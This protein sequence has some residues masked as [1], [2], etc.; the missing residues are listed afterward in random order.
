MK[1]KHLPKRI[2]FNSYRRPQTCRYCGQRIEIRNEGTFIM[3]LL[4]GVIYMS[5]LSGPVRRFIA[6]WFPTL[7]DFITLI[8]TGILVLSSACL[9]EYLFIRYVVKIDVIE[10]DASFDSKKK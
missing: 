10:L 6:G 2:L 8:V 9:L 7:A 3:G 1:C 5:G 4:G